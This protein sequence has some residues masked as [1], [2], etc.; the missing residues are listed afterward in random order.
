MQCIKLA[1][2]VNLKRKKNHLGLK[3]YIPTF[4]TYFSTQNNHCELT[5]QTHKLNWLFC[6]QN[7]G[8]NIGI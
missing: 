8:L 4:D 7:P 2:V 3:E 6:I 1:L 5:T